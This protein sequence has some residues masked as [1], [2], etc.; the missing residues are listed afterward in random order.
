[1][2]D[3]E[4]AEGGEVNFMGLQ[5]CRWYSREALE[6]YANTP[7]RQFKCPNQYKK[8]SFFYIFPQ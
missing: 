4:S 3:L 7:N 5:G 2:N 6:K 1:M 8:S